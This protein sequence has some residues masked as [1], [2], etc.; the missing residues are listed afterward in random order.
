MKNRLC[1]CL[2][3]F[4]R[5]Y[6]M[7]AN[8]SCCCLLYLTVTPQTGVKLVKGLVKEVH[9]GKLLLSDGTWVPYG[10]LVWSTGVGPSDFVKSLDLKKSPGGRSIPSSSSISSSLVALPSQNYAM[11]CKIYVDLAMY[12]ELWERRSSSH[13]IVT[14]KY[15]S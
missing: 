11:N 5:N 12:L 10:L 14:D 1:D 8:Q 4:T 7:R 15:E 9:P 3:H 13:H 6:G 2:V